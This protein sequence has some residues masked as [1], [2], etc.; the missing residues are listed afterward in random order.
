MV[1]EPEY[2][3]AEPASAED[4]DALHTLRRQELFSRHEGVVYDPNHPH[5][6]PPN[7]PLVLRHRGVAIGTA[8]LDP[9]ASDIVVL[10]LVA[11]DRA[12]QGEGH[13]RVLMAMFEELARKRGASRVLVNAHPAA[14]K[15]YERLGYGPEAWD[16]PS[17]AR[18]GIASSCVQMS[19]ALD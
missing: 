8:R 17:G 4:W 5:D 11:I 12:R 2:A 18:G 9:I 14:T 19:K 7:I 10:R 15:F 16:D 13:G 6:R 1:A 3:L